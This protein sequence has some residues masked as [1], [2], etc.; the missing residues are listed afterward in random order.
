MW[1]GKRVV[2]VFPAFNEGE[3]IYEAVVTFYATGIVDDVIVV[4]NNSTDHTAE[5]A[6]K[7]NAT[8]IHESKQG[9]GAALTRGL[10]EATGDYIILAEPDGTFSSTDIIKLLSYADDFDMVCGTRTTRELIWAEANMGWFLRLGNLLVAKWLEMLHNTCSLSD[11]GCTL[12]LIDREAL[13]QFLPFL[14][15]KGSHFLPEMVILARKCGLRIIEIPV[16]YRGRKGM[17]KITGSL[18]GTL[19]TGLNMIWLITAYRFKR[20]VPCEISAR[21]N[22]RC[23]EKLDAEHNG[24]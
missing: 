2:V 13:Q 20:T 16:N 10:T 24:Q 11:C 5:E 18:K 7:A 14:T 8:L 4:N 1:N 22:R 21:P 9:Y 3:S 6:L 19:T 23:P 15:V 17:S 12:R